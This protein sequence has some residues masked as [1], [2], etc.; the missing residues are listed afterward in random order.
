MWF[1]WDN[2]AAT[3]VVV[4][5]MLIVLTSR[6]RLVEAN[7]EQLS[8][9][10]VRTQSDEFASWLEQSMLEVGQL[11]DM[12]SENPIVSIDSTQVYTMDV[13]SDDS[14]KAYTYVTDS[15][16]YE[17]VVVTDDTT[18]PV[19][20]ETQ[21]RRV[22]LDPLPAPK[23]RRDISGGK[24]VPVFNLLIQEKLESAASWSTVGSSPMPVT[25]FKVDLMGGDGYRDFED[26]A[27]ADPGD[28]RNIR[29]RFA[30]LTPYEIDNEGV[31]ELYYGSTLL[32]PF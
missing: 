2:L 3:I 18:D 19:T 24:N 9:T 10:I 30:V 11:M 4:T 20:T 7:I 15:F 5:V 22:Y 14:T 25:Y 29:V 26:L 17:R 32:L 27:I 6:Q 21:Y 1:I 8:S 13:S 16:E 12:T 23:D 31:R 28:I